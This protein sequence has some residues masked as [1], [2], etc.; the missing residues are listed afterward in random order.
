[1]GTTTRKGSTMT[2]ATQEVQLHKL[3][4]A[5]Y[6]A[7]EINGA[8]EAWQLRG[9]QIRSVLIDG[10]PWF[11]AREVCAALGL[12]NVSMAL[13][14][15]DTDE[16]VDHAVSSADTLIE[17][18][19][20][21]AG[22]YSLVL[23]S[24]R[25]Q[26][27]AFKRWVTH[28]VLPAIRKTG[29][30]AAP[31]APKSRVELVRE[32][33]AAEERR[34]EAEQEAAEQRRLL[35][36]AHSALVEVEPKVQAHDALLAVDGRDWSMRDAAAILNRDP[37]IWKAHHLGQ[38]KLFGYLRDLRMVDNANH[39]YAA[40]KQHLRLLPTTYQHPH[41]GEPRASEQLR[42]TPLG[43]VYLQRRLGGGAPAVLQLDVA[44]VPV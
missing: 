41:T 17:P 16:R 24:R 38:N 31:E 13:G 9:L 2:Q 36:R 12:A 29:R 18:L 4:P 35:V 25:P 43:L 6:E 44:Q 3:S 7:A 10:D 22:L 40:H 28:E 34:E 39:I 33:L 15:L 21:E 42:L 19:V 23:T 11:A 37:D 1:M 14:R 30:Y 26:A 8:P 20:S 27:K 32:L 5:V